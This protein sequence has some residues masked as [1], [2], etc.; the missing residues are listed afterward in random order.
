MFW[1]VT[2]G[3]S[4]LL[5]INFYSKNS[6]PFTNVSRAATLS[7]LSLPALEDTYIRQSTPTIN[8]N[9]ST[10]LNVE[11]DTTSEKRTLLKFST[12]ALPVGASIQKIQVKLY[13]T[14]SSVYG[15]TLYQTA[16]SWEGSTVTWNSAPA[17]GTKILDIP[18]ASSNTWVVFDIPLQYISPNGIYSWYIVTTSADAVYYSSKETANVPVMIIDYSLSGSTPQPTSPTA[19]PS[20]PPLL[21]Q[22]LLKQA[23]Q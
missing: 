1:T 5:L 13:V 4:L 17:V 16:S 15:G 19:Q 23:I 7:S 3:I 12:A 22:F 2:I 10:T 21:L 20:L 18:R 8:Y 6:H 11:A 9:S 14:N